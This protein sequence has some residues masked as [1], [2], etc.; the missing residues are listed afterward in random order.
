M[1]NGRRE[2][3]QRSDDDF[4]DRLMERR[5]R[6]RHDKQG[7]RWSRQKV[8]KKVVETVETRRL[9]TW[10]VMDAC[11]SSASAWHR[12]GSWAFAALSY[13]AVAQYTQVEGPGNPPT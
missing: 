11:N 9:L 7:C 6:N 1:L 2:T 8:W 12:Q 4:R 3:V 5:Q 13:N 10:Q